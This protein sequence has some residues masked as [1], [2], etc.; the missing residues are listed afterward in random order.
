MFKE[1]KGG[2]SMDKKQDCSHK[3]TV[4]IDRQETYDVKG[5]K[6]TV[7]AKIRKCEKCNREIFDMIFD[8]ENLKQAYRQYKQKHNLMQ[9]EDI[10]ALRKKYNLTQSMLALLVG[11]TQ[12]TIARYERGSIQS[13]THNTALVLLQN[14]DN[15][16]ATFERKKSEFTFNEKNAFE[17]S[18]SLKE[19]DTAVMSLNLLRNSFDYE[20]DIYSGFKKFDLDKLIATI[21]FFAQNQPLLYKTKLMKLLWY[22]DM[23]FFKENT[24]S[25]TG[26]K[27]VH[28]QYGPIPYKHSIFLSVMEELG[29]VELEEQEYG[30]IILPKTSNNFLDKLSKKELETLRTVNSRFL[31]FKSKDISKLSHTEIGYRNT[32]MKELI[33]YEYAFEMN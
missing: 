15:I 20:Q 33:S 3:I 6:I 26:L 19:T 16:K 1:K 4:I 23:L 27:Y 29:I 18:L 13:E 2:L 28:Q 30:D 24:L 11:C 5:E 25:I 17:K 7:D 22:S 9:S 31:H 32:L 21:S 14:P 12:A 10:L 8:T